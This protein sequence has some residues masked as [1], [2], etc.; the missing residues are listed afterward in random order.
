MI[1]L[2]SAVS[3]RCSRC[4]F[5]SRRILGLLL[6][7]ILITTFFSV[8]GCTTERPIRVNL[9]SVSVDGHPLSVLIAANPTR[10]ATGLMYR[11]ELPE[12]QGMLFIFPQPQMQSF[13]MKNCEIDLDIAY[14]DDAGKIVDI[15][16][17]K[18]PAPGA[19][20]PY[21]YYRSSQPVRY[22]LETNAGWF[23]ARNIEVGGSVE[24]FQGPSGLQ[25][26]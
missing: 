5:L 24:G 18:H 16:T 10:R 15:L 14:I 8:S 17:M 2:P 12:D 7:S 20:G 4:D 25:A 9:H 21:E 1:G 3:G 19:T 13:Y 23:K 11:S 6:V 22:A 26:R